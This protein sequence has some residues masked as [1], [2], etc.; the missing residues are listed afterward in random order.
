MYTEIHCEVETE[1]VCIAHIGP[2]KHAELHEVAHSRFDGFEVY[3]YYDYYYRIIH[4]SNP[5]KLNAKSTLH[6]FP[7]LH[8][9]VCK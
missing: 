1:S 5:A 2:V 7:S 3:A 8:G 9:K 6:T 4:S